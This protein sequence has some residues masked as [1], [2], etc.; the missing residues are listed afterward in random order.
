MAQSV[1]HVDSGESLTVVVN[2]LKSKGSSNCDFY[3]DCDFGQ[4]AYN[5]ARTNAALALTQWLANNPTGSVNDQVLLIGDLNSYSKE[6]PI[7][8]LLNNGFNLVKADGGYSYVFN[9]ET[10][11]LD[12]ALATPSLLSKVINVQDW[13]INTDEPLVLDYNTEYK[14]E[15]QIQSFYAPTPY[16]SSDHDP[17]IVD[18]EFNQAPV[19][20][21]SVYRFLFWYIFISDSFDPDGELAAQTWQLGNYEINKEWFAVPRYL[22]HRQQIREVTLTVTDN[23]G[24]S[25]SMTQ[26]FR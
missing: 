4:G 26:K 13:H 1:T 5:T 21:L 12:H 11:S 19:A 18:F 2:H 9:G 16:R 8:A 23:D 17:V 25:D 7:T 22:V 14:S 24:V 20:E 15:T 6:D 3:G 10:G